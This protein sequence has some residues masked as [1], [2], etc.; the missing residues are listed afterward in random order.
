MFSM[1]TGRDM[2]FTSNELPSFISATLKFYK[3]QIFKDTTGNNGIKLSNYDNQPWEITADKYGGNFYS[4]K[5]GDNDFIVMPATQK[6]VERYKNIK[7]LPLCAQMT[8]M[9]HK[10]NYDII[11]NMLTQ[12]NILT[13]GYTSGTDYGSLNLILLAYRYQIGAK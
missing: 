9:N 10:Y 13:Q 1:E 2:S 3:N 4:Q 7:Q 6:Y 12:N 11:N 5:I 8:Y